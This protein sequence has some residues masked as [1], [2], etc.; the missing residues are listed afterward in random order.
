[1]P[2]RPFVIVLIVRFS[3]AV[4]VTIACACVFDHDTS[5]YTTVDHF[6]R[7]ALALVNSL[8]VQFAL[9]CGWWL[10]SLHLTVAEKIDDS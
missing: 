9:P 8:L 1:M 5:C 4:I 2:S 10:C 3:V 6:I 7:L